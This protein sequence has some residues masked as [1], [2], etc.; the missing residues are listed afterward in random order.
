M[1]AI[2]H[3]TLAG[4]RPG[5]SPDARRAACAESSEMKV[6]TPPLPSGAVPHLPDKQG[7]LCTGT[8]H[9]KKNPSTRHNLTRLVVYALGIFVIG[10]STAHAQTLPG[11]AVD[12][13]AEVRFTTPL[14]IAAA[15]DSNV[16]SLTTQ[17][18]PTDAEIAFVQ[19]GEAGGDQSIHP[20]ECVS[21]TGAQML[22]DP[23]LFSGA[24]V[25]SNGLFTIDDAAFFH[26]GDPL[27]VQLDDQDQNLDATALDTIAVTISFAATGDS[28]D[29]NLTETDVN[30]GLFVG[31]IPTAVSVASANDCVLQVE[32]GGQA[33]ASYTDPN[34]ATDVSASS[35]LVD[36]LGIVFDSGN[37][38]PINGAEVRLINQATGLPATVFGDDGVSTYPSEV[39]TGG[40]V[41]D[42]GG[43][44]YIFD[45]GAFRFPLIA[46]GRYRLEVIP[47]P[48]Y[49][50][51]SIVAINDLQQ[52]PGAPFTLVPASFGAEFVV[53]PGPVV[54][55]DVPLDPSSAALFLQKTSPL[56][57][58]APGDFVPY[59]LRVDN[60]DGVARV[61]D[62]RITDNLP[63]GFRLVSDSVRIDGQPAPD[64]VID[65]TGRGLT[66]LLGTLNGGQSQRVS[67]VTEV[68]NA[69]RGEEAVNSAVAAGNGGIE[70]NV[71]S[72]TNTLT[73]DLFASN[74]FL[75]GRVIN[76]SCD[77][78]VDN[79]LEGVAN[80]R[81]YLEDG[82]YA[83]TDEGGR[84][85]FEGVE[86]G[87]HVVQLDVDS[88]PTHMEVIPCQNNSRF[89]GRA[90]SQFVDLRAGSLW[91]AD[92][93]LQPIPPADGAV[94]VLL[95]SRPVADGVDYSL[96]VLGRGDVVIG[97]L[98]ALV[99]MPDG[100]EYVAGSAARNG[101]ALDNPAVNG[102]LLT[103]RLGT[104]E[105]DWQEIVTFRARY[106]AGGREW[107]TKAMA[108][109][110]AGDEK[111]R[112]PLVD[113]LLVFEPSVEERV[114]FTL[115]PKFG[116]RRAQLSEADRRDID[117][118]IAQIKGARDIRVH[119]VG[120]TDNVPIAP[121]N[122]TEFADNRVLSHARAAGVARYVRD[123][124][125]L[126]PSQMT[127]EGK[128]ADQPRESNATPEGRKANRRVAL[129][130][131]G[132]KPVLN[133][134]R[135][136]AAG[137]RLLS[138][139]QSL[140]V[141]GTTSAPSEPLSRAQA[142]TS[143]G[144][145][146]FADETLVETLEPGFELLQPAAD[147]NL[148]IPSLKI[149]V[150]H[151]PDQR[152]QLELNDQ[153]V[154]GIHYE[155]KN[156]NG[157]RTVA[158]SRWRGVNVEPGQNRLSVVLLDRN[159]HELERI[160]R[161]VHFSGGP[162][163]AEL[164]VNAST[165]IADGRQ[166]PVIVLNTFDRE[167]YPGRPEAVGVY[168][169]EPPYRSMWE[170]NAARENQLVVVGDRDP[171]Y[172][173]N[174]KGQAIIELEPTSQAGEVVLNLE[175]EN[176][177][178]Q[179]IRA[180]LKPAA[181]DW[182]LVG[183]AEGT[184]GYNTLR[185]N[186]ENASDD[187]LED[188]FYEEGR[189]AFFAKGR[190]RGDFLLTL[191]YDTRG[192]SR[193][194]LFGTID[195]DRFY[196]LYGDATEQRFD[197][198][199]QEKLFLKIERNQF[200]ALFGD[201]QTGLTVTELSRYNRS[202]TG[203]KSEYVGERFGYNVFAAETNQAFVKD[204]IAGDGTS[205]LYQLSRRPII[206][207]SEKV[208]LE[209]RDRF[210][211]EVIVESRS[212]ARHLDY[213]ID[214]LQGTL[215]FKQ[216][217]LSRDAQ[218]NPVFIVVDYESRDDGDDE[219]IAG[220]RASY[221]P[222][223]NV[224][225]GATA[226]RE[227]MAGGTGELMG[228]D[229]TVIVR[230]G[231]ELR[232]EYATSDSTQNG[233]ASEGDAY[234]LELR[235]QGEK[236]DGVVYTRE[237][238][239]GFG[240]G[241]QRG[242]ESGTR[243]TGFAGRL[244]MSRTLTL[245]TDV[246]TQKNLGNGATRDVVQGEVRYQSG[247]ATVGVGLRSAADE[248]ETGVSRKSEQ[249]FVNGSYQL[250]DNRL[251]L[252]G[253]TDFS[254]GDNASGDFPRRTLLGM[255]Y[256]LNDRVTV[257]GEYEVAEGDNIEAQT[258]RGGIKVTPWERANVNASVNRAISEYGPRVFANVGLV[259][260]FQLNDKVTLD[261]GFDHGNT[262]ATPEFN[263][264]NIDT[265]PTSGAIGEDFTSVFVGGVYR[266]EDWS[267]T[268]RLELRRSDLEDR[269]TLQV[270]F[271]REEKE[272]VGFSLN[273]QVFNS[274]SGDVNNL[275]ADVRLGL[276]YRPA[277][278]EWAIFDRLDLGYD[279]FDSLSDSRR[280][281]KVVNNLN[282]NWMM[283]RDT[284]IDFQYGAKFVRSN[285]ADQSYTGF[286]DLVGVA[287]RHDVN[288]R[289]DVGLHGH[290]RHAWR[291]DVY[292]YSIGFEAGVTVMR[293]AWVSVGYNVTGFED[294]DFS[295]AGYLASG[296]YI[297]FRLKADQHTFDDFRRGMLF[298]RED[299]AVN[300]ARRR[301]RQ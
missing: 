103:F 112:T 51:P 78:T 164:D 143:A 206:I 108:S 132:E 134:R 79:D 151:A 153:P 35:A 212:L 127:V 76:G 296:P 196:T 65:S 138:D 89:A 220:G 294:D 101:Q 255:D 52:L 20:T 290:V 208:T 58:A 116:T 162:V 215:F 229:L 180:W 53:N 9:P 87:A 247:R 13:V 129:S 144:P 221:R 288:D 257:F 263:D 260:G 189:L 95:E 31:Y 241:Q 297:R 201:H 289:F 139:L 256:R 154:N 46:P 182:I 62:V 70:S 234:S 275:N 191:A 88:I 170:V 160:E 272:G 94:D 190:I 273:A 225:L 279:D 26:G 203:V 299:V 284:Q 25:D 77:D 128:G 202:L 249:A 113:N 223:A 63:A 66:F 287:W 224:E 64:P 267:A 33:Q 219:L 124:L 55:I 140:T 93:Y 217:V 32:L 178:E 269:E 21:A 237:Q 300:T 27:F 270:G 28:E 278:S 268:S 123:E 43:T 68:T 83:I 49:T 36:P 184:V 250:L 209:V 133:S 81:I 84:F 99:L 130:I 114:E 232:A 159:N 14:G 6:A 90:F 142:V 161:I 1:Q 18:A 50:G 11:T 136:V 17:L 251:T 117:N 277:D 111:K 10:L 145:D 235:H 252:R 261:A 72:A 231:T 200:Y 74:S 56:N 226:I 227:G 5:M 54:R 265:P 194:R 230:P 16:V 98:E 211:T 175:F 181:R 165:L 283:S 238:Q 59:E 44:Q 248:D 92:F 107:L 218:F 298:R 188:D 280:S 185:D 91:R 121:Q 146:Y 4:V 82:R 246:Y 102:S 236:L 120:H 48:G 213:N 293:N 37:G 67:Y 254:L 141:T 155:G 60:A 258:S 245:N 41:T 187:G 110:E 8:V 228:A 75:I 242:T 186:L 172:T 197:A 12:N 156:R 240:L 122:R 86:P 73:E 80:T 163:R 262:L 3:N 243:K 171:V 264:F 104:R 292:D 285:I 42:S 259:Q 198:A 169:V 71:A 207:N 295:Q 47:P 152:V 281:W 24:T 193:D 69:I 183:L 205:G 166:R 135:Q 22:P 147:E 176:G 199:S 106:G 214:Y 15:I 29:L 109:F 195:P 253:S 126:L 96:T 233:V 2:H 271:Y 7:R 57:V 23:K 137:S 119:I 239:S 276:A 34:D 38:A 158:V 100:A 286:S 149:A 157:A 216:P 30:T 85:H 19:V 118:V 244:R 97:D 148:A 39:I 210:R 131:W 61:D 282:L 192:R 179:E 301:A 45:D 173:L 125:G 167:Q 222:V 105:G 204:E 115:T 274:E 168:H 177:L 40:S 266:S 174:A 150:K 291:S